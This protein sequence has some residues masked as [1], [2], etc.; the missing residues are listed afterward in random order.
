MSEHGKLEQPFHRSVDA[1]MGDPLALTCSINR[2][3]A[4]A[5]PSLRRRGGGREREQTKHGAKRHAY[6]I[7]DKNKNHLV[8]SSGMN[9][10]GMNTPRAAAH[11]RHDAATNRTPEG[12]TKDRGSHGIS[13]K[14]FKVARHRHGQNFGVRKNIFKVAACSYRSER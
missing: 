14:N 13:V 3:D 8:S 5:Q 4:G 7:I 2:S 1:Q 12:A 6:I 10:S 11:L 9:T